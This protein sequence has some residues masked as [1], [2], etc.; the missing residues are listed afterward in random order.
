[1][2]LDS[3]IIKPSSSEDQPLAKAHYSSATLM[4]SL[5][6]K[7]LPL[8]STI[9]SKKC[10]IPTPPSTWNSGTR[11]DKK[12]IARSSIITSLCRRQG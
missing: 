5:I 7:S 10:P 9:D 11:P 6:L 1:M 8:E 2:I 12:G 3:K 4:E